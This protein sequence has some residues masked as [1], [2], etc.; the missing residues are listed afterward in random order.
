[1]EEADKSDERD[2]AG[3]S[4]EDEQGKE[5]KSGKKDGSGKR[6]RKRA[7]KKGEK[8]KPGAKREKISHGQRI[9]RLIWSIAHPV[10]RR[11][12][13]AI[14]DYGE[15]CSPAQIATELELPL[16]M[17]T[18]HT[19]VLRNYGAVEPVSERQARGAIEHFYDSAIEDSPSIENL[20]EETREAD[21]EET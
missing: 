3:K 14:R 15:D 10:R 18:Y 5:D 4:E 2:E 1:M 8:R 6:K 17:V 9:A 13:R 12:L 20:L 11:I 21:D 7:R 16:S 19:A